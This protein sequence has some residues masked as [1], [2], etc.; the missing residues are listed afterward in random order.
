LTELDRGVDANS[1]L[2]FHR[3]FRDRYPRLGTSGMVFLETRAEII[4]IHR[5]GI[6][7][8]SPTGELLDAV[9]ELSGSLSQ[10]G[11]DR[12]QRSVNL[13]LYWLSLITLVLGYPTIFDKYQSS[14]TFSVPASVALT[15][16]SWLLGGC[17]LI[18]VWAMIRHGVILISIHS[19][20]RILHFRWRTST[21]LVAIKV[22]SL[23]GL[24]FL[25]RRAITQ[26]WLSWIE[27]MVTASTFVPRTRGPL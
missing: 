27:W 11:N 23:P 12:V 14:A 24:R 10:E 16:I 22:T 26:E 21:Q 17:A 6:Q 1:A 18:L 8:I 2:S 19:M 5:L 25:K 9:S 4:E 7:E 13:V 15:R 20:S 3:K